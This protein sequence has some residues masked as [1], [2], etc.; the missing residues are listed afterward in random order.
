MDGCPASNSRWG[1]A[2]VYALGKKDVVAVTESVT[3][4]RGP[5]IYKSGYV[6]SAQSV[7]RGDG[8]GREKGR[9]Q[10]ERLFA[11]IRRID[12]EGG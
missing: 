2:H 9:S 10:R 5:R 4:H 11:K 12:P 3:F 8:I 6:T 1:R 7:I